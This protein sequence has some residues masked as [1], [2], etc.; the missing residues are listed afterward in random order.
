MATATAVTQSVPAMKV[1]R[2]NS[3]LRGCHE[4]E[5]RSSE[6]GLAESIGRDLTYSPTIIAN[7]MSPETTVHARMLAPASLSFMSLIIASY[8]SSLRNPSSS[9]S[10][11]SATY[12][13]SATYRCPSVRTHLTNSATAPRAGLPRDTK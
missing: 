5:K 6:R 8:S 2:P 1:K 10:P 9:L 11:P 4:V 3:P 7:T 13:A 12:P